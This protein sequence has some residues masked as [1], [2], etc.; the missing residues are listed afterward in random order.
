MHLAPLNTLY[1]LNHASTV[2]TKGAAS[3]FVCVTC[4]YQYEIDKNQIQVLG[5]Q[6]KDA[7]RDDVQGRGN[8]DNLPQTSGAG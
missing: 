2:D 4:P 7:N 6:R 8:Q 1:M 3:R 5:I